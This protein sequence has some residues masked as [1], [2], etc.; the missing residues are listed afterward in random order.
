[1]EEYRSRANVDSFDDGGAVDGDVELVKS[2]RNGSN[3][4]EAFDLTTPDFWGVGK[5]KNDEGLDGG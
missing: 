1:L 5:G 4:L 2:V 3:R